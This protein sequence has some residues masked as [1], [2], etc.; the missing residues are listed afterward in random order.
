MTSI[1]VSYQLEWRQF[2]QLTSFHCDVTWHNMSDVIW[3]WRHWRFVWYRSKNGRFV[4]FHRDLVKLLFSFFS[5]A[6]Q[7]ILSAFIY[8]FIENHSSLFHDLT[9]IYSHP[10][11]NDRD[12]GSPWG[13][14]LPDGNLFIFYPNRHDF[15]N[16]FCVVV[17]LRRKQ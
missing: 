16:D 12:F 15:R 14:I 13:R 1:D 17:W 7:L 6:G 8:L 2:S 10:W 11:D 5:L 3:R 4:I 9:I